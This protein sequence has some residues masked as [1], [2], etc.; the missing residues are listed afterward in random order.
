MLV[1]IVWY[2]HMEAMSEWQLRNDQSEG[3]YTNQ[4]YVVMS[5]IRHMVHEDIRYKSFIMRR[6]QFM[7][8][9]TNENCVHPVDC[10]INKVSYFKEF[11]MLCFFS[12]EKNFV[13]QKNINRRNGITSLTE[14]HT[15]MH[16][17]FLSSVMFL[18]VVS[19]EDDVS[20]NTFPP[21]GRVNAT[22]HRDNGHSWI[23]E[24]AHG[25]YYVYCW[26]CAG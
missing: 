11:S 23:K 22:L 7:S 3:H 17:K 16:R 14:V 9:R 12:N 8:N 18:E 26:G 13:Q 1:S 10:L 6:G 21:Q 19:N 15:V 5:A 25:K 20:L 2:N 24:A 4:L